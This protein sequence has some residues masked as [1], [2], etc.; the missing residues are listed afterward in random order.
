MTANALSL[1]GFTNRQQNTTVLVNPTC[2][3]PLPAHLCTRCRQHQKEEMQDF[4]RVRDVECGVITP[5]RF[6]QR[7]RNVTWNSSVLQC[8]A[9]VT[10]NTKGNARNITP[11]WVGWW[12]AISPLPFL[13]CQHMHS[14]QSLPLLLCNTYMKWTLALV[15]SHGC[16]SSE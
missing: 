7:W 2:P 5:L 4:H 8:L 6:I 1:S 15:E 16:I 12:D 11:P 10:S 9:W 13:T 14:W 3:V